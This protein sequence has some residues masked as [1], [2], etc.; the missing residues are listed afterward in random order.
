MRFA[1]MRVDRLLERYSGPFLLGW[2]MLISYLHAWGIARLAEAVIAG[3]APNRWRSTKPRAQ[4]RSRRTAD[5]ILARNPFDSATG[6]L[7]RAPIARVVPSLAD[8]LSAPQC[9]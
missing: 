5:A 8:P 3:H 6:P 1:I 2:L 9:D 4:V 7:G